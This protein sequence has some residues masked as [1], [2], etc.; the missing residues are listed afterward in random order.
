MSRSVGAVGIMSG[1][2]IDGID[3]VLLEI[4]ESGRPLVRATR[5]ATFPPALQQSIVTLTQPGDNEL[6]LAGRVDIELGQRYADLAN[7]L[8]ADAGE[9]TV[10][11]IGSHGQTVRHRPDG[12][13][14]FTLQLGSGAV[15]AHRTGVSTVTDFRSADMA[16][17]GQGAPFAPFF[18][19]AV[20]RSNT[21][22][23]AI[24]NLGGIA[25]VTLLPGDPDA[26]VW[27]FDSGPA[28]GLMDAWIQ[29]HCNKP[30]DRNGEW[31]RAGDL[32]NALLDRL[33]DHPYIARP[34]PKSTGREDFHIGWLDQVLAEFKNKLP[35]G[36]IQRTLA[37][38]TATSI[39][40]Q[41]P[42]EFEEIYT[43]G[44][45][46]KNQYLL[47][48]LA[49]TCQRPVAT[50]SDLGFDPGQ[51]EAAAFAWFAAR[52]LG[53]QTTTLPS[54]TGASRPTVT[55]TVYYAG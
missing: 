2:S 4:P 6:D 24:I 13:Y 43:C 17:G 1:T 10:S 48:L 36:N 30:F 27:G 34:Y 55:G 50:T 28:N 32:Q 51:V 14:P 9:I 22:S 26:A 3:G 16:A 47:E 21:R 23:R 12:E 5:S 19:N 45:G 8:I 35:A 46:A 41:I 39:G 40:R 49:D 53:K 54:V 25:N 33:L 29:R 15:I 11:V 38:F 18:H 44:G 20:F 52:T 7:A 37:Q 42:G 31:A